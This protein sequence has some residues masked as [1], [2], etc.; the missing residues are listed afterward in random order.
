MDKAVEYESKTIS[1]YVALLKRH[2]KVLIWSALSISLSG[3]YLAYSLPAMY[4]STSRFLIESQYIPDNIVQSTVTTYVDEQI[5][6]VRQRVTSSRNVEQLIDEHGL[7]PELTQTAEVQAAVD[8]FRAHTAL[9][10][11]VFDVINPRSGRAAQATISF[12]VSFDH[13]DPVVA[14]DVAAK[15]ANLYLSENVQSRTEQI[16]Q[17]AEFIRSDIERYTREVESTG[18]ALADFKE[19]NLGTLPE[20]MNYNLQTIE[21]TERQ[22]DAMERDI[23]DAR[24]RQLQLSSEL[25]RYEAT[26]TIYDESGTPLLNPTEQLAELQREKM[27]LISIYSAEHPDVIQIQKEIELLSNVAS[28]SGTQISDIEAQVDAARIE[29]AQLRQRY[30]E[31][32]P[33]VVRS[34]R[35]LENLE[36][37]LERARTENRSTAM[38]SA[39]SD[40]YEQ[41]LRVRIQTDAANVQS[42]TR[43]KA[44]L[45]EKL[46]ELESK[47]ALS[48][49]IEREYDALNQSN[50]TAVANLNDARAKLEEAIKAE[51]LEAEGG[52]DKFTIIE[53]ANLPVAPYKPNRTAIILLALVLSIGFGI[54]VATVLDAMDESVKGSR[55]V[56]RIINTPPLAVIPYVETQIEHKQR[57]AANFGTVALV[58]GGIV[59]AIMIASFAG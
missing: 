10:T 7:Y 20:L 37:V 38:S 32:H 23:Q 45:E 59:I 22:I 14:R 42:L 31:D 9:E 15:L 17:A 56:L 36:L 33:D 28:G 25:A 21:R 27:R 12:T 49:R 29:L 4:R 54:V 6:G 26:D 40:P 50:L 51:K 58:M 8:E 39:S 55:D 13:T 41:Q 16:H 34:S 18:A 46:A 57:V 2:N 24:N 19:Q 44:E 1:D 3:V 53:P 5:Q 47:V 35:S 30:S 48:P 43:R 11:E 52:G